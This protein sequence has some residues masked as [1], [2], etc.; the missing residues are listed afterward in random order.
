[1]AQ[2]SDLTSY[3]LVNDKSGAET[4]AVQISPELRHE[5]AENEA[6]QAPTV[7]CKLRL[8]FPKKTRNELRMVH[9]PTKTLIAVVNPSKS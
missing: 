6:F 2:Q 8:N 9:V 5:S 4:T 1:M 3:V 7:I